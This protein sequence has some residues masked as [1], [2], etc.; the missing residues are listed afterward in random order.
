[1]SP[2]ILAAALLLS[3]LHGNAFA[4]FFLLEFEVKFEV[5]AELLRGTCAANDWSD[6]SQD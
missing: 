5:I 2:E 4:M 1:M 3:R 6:M